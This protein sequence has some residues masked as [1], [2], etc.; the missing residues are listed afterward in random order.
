M[1]VALRAHGPVVKER[2]KN[3]EE[4]RLPVATRLIFLKR[5]RG[6]HRLRRSPGS[7][8]NA[9]GVGSASLAEQACSLVL[10]EQKLKS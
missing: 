10:E 9:F 8:P 5:V 4:E 2:M 7:T 6:F 1:P 3:V